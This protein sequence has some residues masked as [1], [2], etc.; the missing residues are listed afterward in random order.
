MIP[1][2]TWRENQPTSEQSSNSQM[3][4]ASHS[5]WSQPPWSSTGQ[6]VCYTAHRFNGYLKTAEFLKY[7]L[8]YRSVG[9]MLTAVNMRSHIWIPRPH[10]KSS[11]WC[12]VPLTLVLVGQSQKVPWVCWPDNLAESAQVQWE[13]LHQNT[14]M[15]N[16]HTYMYTFRV[17]PE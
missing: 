4:K 16:L 11:V 10:I 13:S 3:S 6:W 14:K 9:Q 12:Y 7:T 5:S 2:E 15:K 17:N 1:R 8:G